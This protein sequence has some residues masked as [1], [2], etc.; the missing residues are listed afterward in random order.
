[1]FDTFNFLEGFGVNHFIWI[2]FPT[3]IAVAEFFGKHREW[4]EDLGEGEDEEEELLV[5]G[6]EEEGYSGGELNFCQLRSE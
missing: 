3:V 2:T 1:L 5:D 6:E 4:E